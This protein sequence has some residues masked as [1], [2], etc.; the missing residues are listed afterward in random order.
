MGTT[1]ISPTQKRSLIFHPP[2]APDTN[3]GWRMSYF[4]WIQNDVA[5]QRRPN[6]SKMLPTCPPKA[7]RTCLQL[8][9]DPN[10]MP[11]EVASALHREPQDRILGVLGH[12]F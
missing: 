3:L 1:A 4:V 7:S 11:N 10:R 8:Q 6:G 12:R 2:P 5:T 9:I